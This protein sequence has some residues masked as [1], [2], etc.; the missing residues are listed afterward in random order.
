[1]INLDTIILAAGKGARMKSDLPKVLHC[2]GGKP[3]ISHVLLAA[4]ALEQQSGFHIVVGHGAQRLKQSLEQQAGI[5]FVEQT[6]QLGTGHAVQQA[7]P[8]LKN[9]S[10]ALILYG[11]VPLIQPQT[12]KQLIDKVDHNTLALLTVNLQNPTGYGR[13][14]RNA[15][16][17]VKS[18]VEQKDASTEEL[19]IQEINTGIMAVNTSQLQRWLPQL[20][21]DNTQ[22]EYYLTD[23][24]A[25]AVAEGVNIITHQPSEQWEVMGINNRQQQA[26]L[27]RI[28]QYNCAQMLMEAGVS[29]LDPQR[30]DCRGQLRCGADVLIDINC[31]FEG[32]NTIGNNVV[33]GSNC[34]IKNATIGDNTLIHANSIIENSTVK[35]GCTIGPF[36]RLRPGSQLADGAKVGNFVET[37]KAS[38]GKGSKINHL[39]YVGDAVLGENVNIGAGTITCNYDGV[40]KFQTSI[41][42]DVFVGSNTA[43]VAPV[44]IEDGATLGAGSTINKNVKQ[45]TLALARSPQKT[46]PG[47]QKPTKKN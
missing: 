13:I 34:V 10:I 41:G 24:I 17:R 22:A 6:Q 44:T 42:N 19:K 30:F 25:M 37:K 7:L 35:S 32:E 33:I 40:N 45:D 23:I 15:Q 11:D 31:I 4:Q 38:I 12:L 29:L 26:Q 18:I 36:A 2:I 16:G 3:L 47:W 46:I 21:N 14:I 20:S 1:M 27:E 8:H 39:S 43:L 28:Y 9:D 5:N